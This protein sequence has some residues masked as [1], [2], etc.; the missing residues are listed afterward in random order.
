MSAL[1]STPTKSPR[2]AKA[3]NTVDKAL[4]GGI[5]AG[6]VAG[7][8]WLLALALGGTALFIMVIATVL[9]AI[10]MVA[11]GAKA[12]L[13]IWVVI[14]IGW[15]LIILER[16]L[17]NHH[18][19]LWVAAAAW[20]GIVIGAR[21]AGISKR[22]MILLLYPLIPGAIVVVSHES[23]L[24]PWGVGWLWVLA[25]LGPV[26]GMRTLL[27]PS[28]RGGDSKPAPQRDLLADL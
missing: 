24:N 25:I 17:V 20:I 14:A 9:A 27:N 23:L 8:A 21:R 6:A 16:A 5:L 18:G 19:G 1:A 26:I 11:G 28:P 4:R 15:V 22:W 10:Y 13:G 12:R 7:I 2:K 3:A